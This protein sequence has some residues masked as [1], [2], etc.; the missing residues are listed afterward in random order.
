M[1]TFRKQSASA[2]LQDHSHR[3]QTTLSG[4]AKIQCAVGGHRS[5][6]GDAMKL[7]K[8]LRN[9]MNRR[10]FDR[11][12]QEEMGIHREMAEEKLNQLGTPT[13]EAYY[14]AMRTFG[15][16]T[17]AQEA[18]RLEWSFFFE[19]LV[20]DIGFGVRMLHRSPGFTAVAVLTLALGIGANTA[21]F[22]V[23]NAVLFRPL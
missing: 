14:A 5:R 23:V 16:P 2:L 18:S 11:D 20:Q 9:L 15:N 4:K 12:L 13:E 21:I 6:D 1:G 3:P 22:S 19:S 7:W 10:A 17:I 8:K